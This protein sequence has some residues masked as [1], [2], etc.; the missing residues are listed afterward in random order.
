MPLVRIDMH[1][2]MAHR[3]RELSEAIHEGLVEGLP[4]P[5]DDL[6]QIFRLHEPGDLIYTASFPNA[7]RSDIIFIQILLRTSTRRTTSS[8]CTSGLSATSRLSVSSPT[9][10]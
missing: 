5:K 10:C 3:R 1:A 6:F 2:D 9:M 7:E 8:A 4:M